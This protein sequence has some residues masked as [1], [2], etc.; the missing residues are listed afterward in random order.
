MVHGNHAAPA[1]S[2]N[3]FAG[4]KR[5][6]EPRKPPADD[7]VHVQVHMHVHV[8][9]RTAHARACA[10][11][12][13][14][15]PRASRRVRPLRALARGCTR[16][17]VRVRVCVLRPLA[18]RPRSAILLPVARLRGACALLHP[19]HLA[20]HR[21]SCAREFALAGV[22]QHCEHVSV[23]RRAPVAPP[24]APAPQRAPGQP[25][26]YVRAVGLVERGLAAEAGDGLLAPIHSRR[27]RVPVEALAKL[28]HGPPDVGIVV[29]AVDV[30]DD[31]G[32]QEWR[33]GGGRLILFERHPARVA[34]LAGCVLPGLF[35]SAGSRVALALRPGDGATCLNWQSLPKRHLP[36][37]KSRHALSL[38]AVGLRAERRGSRVRGS[39]RERLRATRVSGREL[40]RSGAGRLWLGSVKWSSEARI[41]VSAARAGSFSVRI[42]A[43]TA[44]Y[45]CSWM[46]RMAGADA[47]TPCAMAASST[48]RVHVE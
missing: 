35:C 15:L 21:R 8:H 23:A 20:F 45:D 11:V 9:M 32:G 43:E 16:M 22:G 47:S 33:V 26:P 24:P 42:L 41:L 10:H 39:E 17:R 2:L 5:G 28:A 29:V 34:P 37:W 4:T 25:G 3:S 30:A 6:R 12:R 7:H 18:R 27:P 14:V 19:G 40:V 38:S 36:R 46:L 31:G 1:P 13:G 44:R 48:L